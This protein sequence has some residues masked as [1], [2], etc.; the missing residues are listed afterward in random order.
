MKNTDF[1]IV[2][3]LA[4]ALVLS[5]GCQKKYEYPYALRLTADRIEL[6]MY[7]GESCVVVYS[8]TSWTAKMVEEKPWAELVGNGGE[9]IGEVTLRFTENP[10]IARMAKMALAAGNVKDTVTFVQNGAISA[11]DFSFKESIVNIEGAAGN[12]PIA[13]ETNVPD[14]QDLVRGS[15]VYYYE[16]EALE[17]IAV[18][19]TG[20]KL[21]V[22]KWITGFKYEDGNIVVSVKGNSDGMRRS[23][24]FYLLLD[25]GVGISYKVSVRIRQASL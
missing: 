15:V 2:A 23:A 9:G 7:E 25:N 11:P 1:R 24:D 6:N 22:D 13:F 5:A 12:Y 8:N 14:L 10:S 18:G 21:P 3:C 20:K 17:E 16:G 4:L 19:D